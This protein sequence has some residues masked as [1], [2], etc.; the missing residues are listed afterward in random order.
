MSGTLRDAQDFPMN[1]WDRV[2]VVL[3]LESGEM[4][5]VLTEA[6]STDDVSKDVE[7]HS[8]LGQILKSKREEKP[9]KEIEKEEV[10]ENAE[11]HSI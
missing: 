4:V 3:E 7:K 8:I 5:E 2:C 11:E 9:T 10:G 1:K 6:T